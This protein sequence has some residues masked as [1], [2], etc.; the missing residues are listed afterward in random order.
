MDGS[1]SF[2][3]GVTARCSDGVCG[4]VTQVVLDP[5]DDRVTHV[6]VEPE[7]RQGLGRL[8]PIELAEPTSDEID[9][10]CTLAEFNNL[11][12]A[13]RVRFLAGL[14]G[15][16]GYEPD[17]LLLWPYFG[18]NITEPEVVDILPAGEVAIQRGETVHASDGRIGEVEGMVVAR[19]D[20]RASH[21][22]LK[23]GHLFGRKDVA[24]PIGAVKAVSEQGITLSLSKHE[25]DVLP[26]VEFDRPGR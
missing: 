25:V 20:H 15:L 18:G 10:K 13:E 2:T 9:I 19:S 7:H 22:V 16:K 17:D 1:A 5:I 12:M 26:A 23:T 24:I 21:I 3:I 8:V 11:K 6:I 14:D 4:R